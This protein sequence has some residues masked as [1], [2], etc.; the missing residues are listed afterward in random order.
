MVMAMVFS[1]APAGYAADLDTEEDTVIEEIVTGEMP[2]AEETA[3]EQELP[4]EPAAEEIPAA[5][6]MAEEPAEEPEEETAEAGEPVDVVFVFTDYFVVKVLTADGTEIPATEALAEE[7]EDGSVFYKSVCSLLPGEYSY[8][9]KA[10]AFRTIEATLEV[11]EEPVT[12]TL[13]LEAYPYGFIGMPLDFE[14]SESQTEE[15]S[16]MA[17]NNADTTLAGLTPGT[18]YVD[19][20]VLLAA[21]TEEF[22]EAAAEAYNAE[23]RKYSHGIAVLTLNDATVYEAVIA[24]MDPGLNLPVVNP[25]HRYAAETPVFTECEAGESYANSVM[26]GS[27]W[28]TWKS[29]V[30]K[31]DEYVKNPSASKYQYFH[32]VINSY[33]A[34]NAG[35]KGY[36]VKVGVIDSGVNYSHKD[37]V[38]QNAWYDPQSY[39][40]TSGKDMNGHGT[41]VSGIIGARQGNGIGGSGVAPEC[42]LYS[43]RVIDNSGFVTDDD[44][45]DALDQARLD[46]MKV[47]N[48]S[49]GGHYYNQYEYS[50]ISSLISSG[51]TVVVAMG[52][53]GS[54]IKC[55]PAAYNVP[56]LITV[57]ATNEVNKRASFSNYSSGSD[58]WLDVYAPGENILSTYSN[59]KYGYMSGT[60]QATPVVAGLVALYLQKNPGKSPADV[61]TAIKNCVADGGNG[62]SIVNAKKLLGITTTPISPKIQVFDGNEN[63]SDRFAASEAVPNNYTVK[64]AFAQDP[65]AG[66]RILFTTDGTAPALENGEIVC[67]AVYDD[68]TGISLAG[69]CEG[70]EITICAMSVSE[71]GYADDVVSWTLPIAC[72]Q[73][74]KDNAIASVY[75]DR[76]DVTLSA[77]GDTAQIEAEAR[78]AEGEAVDAE[79]TEVWT[80]SDEGILTVENG[81]VTAVAPGSAEIVC[82][83]TAADG[84]AAESRC[85]ASVILTTGNWRILNPNETKGY[86][87]YCYSGKTTQMKMAYDTAKAPTTITSWTILSAPAGVTI[88]SKGA[89]KVPASVTSGSITLRATAK[90]GEYSDFSSNIK[91]AANAIA[92]T[93]LY[94]TSD[95]YTI[96]LKRGTTN[97]PT[98]ATLFTSNYN[99]CGRTNNKIALSG[100][101]SSALGT[102]SGTKIKWTSSKPSVAYVSADSTSNGGTL[103][104]YAQAPGST[105]ITGVVQDANAKKITLKVTVKTPDLKITAPSK[106]KQAV[107]VS[108]LDKTAVSAAT[109][110]TVD[111]PNSSRNEKILQLKPVLTNFKE[112]VVWSSS[113]YSVVDVNSSGLV[114]AKGFGTATVTCKIGNISKTCSFTVEVPASRIKISSS[115]QQAYQGSYAFAPGTTITNTILYGNA[116]GDLETSQI[117]NTGVTWSAKLYKSTNMRK[118]SEV[119]NAGNYYFTMSSNGKLYTYNNFEYNRY[120]YKIVVTAVTNDG[121]KLKDSIE[122][123]LAA[124]SSNS[125]YELVPSEYVM[126]FGGRTQYT[127]YLDTTNPVFYI[128]N[129][130]SDFGQAYVG[131]ILFSTYYTFTGAQIYTVESDNPSVC[132]AVPR[133]TDGFEVY[134]H[135]PGTAHITIKPL[136]GSGLSART[137]TVVVT[138]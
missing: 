78:N 61:E 127:G 1:L 56:G 35:Y 86:G 84:T 69:L 54:N 105:T 80:S 20:E 109:L 48:L 32:E 6:E 23:I 57:G 92:L 98:A 18:D 93:A 112:P 111:Y 29:S 64:L 95:A 62:I 114:T 87:N 110:W 108:M 132:G 44:F 85:T 5:E 73:V 4:D 58:N 128:S 82:T 10:R 39:V 133:Y 27:S 99:V 9:V 106:S 119:S 17:E 22:A 90:N 11:A 81:L 12:V 72:A 33:A 3:N 66:D 135:S 136:D 104:V 51:C 65:N 21:D 91:E 25:N 118:W 53:D 89:V 28:D 74:K 34:W 131:V 102:A 79:V 130:R 113:N 100:T 76:F 75:M 19:G 96:T 94:P 117:E 134:P 120:L 42:S 71:E 38:I 8:S 50:Y 123:R 14:L 67:G 43:Y 97:V 88:S 47:V 129:Y 63:V 77:I 7:A 83:M 116:Y 103:T 2:A 59:G 124:P 125:N 52:N 122:Y 13:E 107:S 24:G 121:T 40:N 26:G 68:E 46:G 115:L 41:H 31:P 101:Y 137:L 15:K 16:A 70:D 30:A 55:Y 138:D 36:G 49:L 126:L 60:S 37:L 45:L